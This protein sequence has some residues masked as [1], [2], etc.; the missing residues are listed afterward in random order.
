M[1]NID[2]KVKTARDREIFQ[3]TKRFGK[4]IV[5]KFYEANNIGSKSIEQN[6]LDLNGRIVYGHA[7]LNK[8]D[9]N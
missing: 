2:F 3:V 5:I 7:T 9:P 8:L 4:T 6:F 1:K